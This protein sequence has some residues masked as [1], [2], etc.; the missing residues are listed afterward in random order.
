MSQYLL[1]IDQGTSSSRAVIYDHSVAV[2][3]SAQQE[4]PQIYAQAGWVE[5]DPE[6]IWSSVRVVIRRAMQKVGAAASDVTAIGVTN[7]RETTLIWDRETG[8]SVYNAIVWQDRRTAE[9]CRELKE[10]GAEAQIAHGRPASALIP[11][12]QRPRLRGFSTTSRAFGERAE[13]GKLAFGT[14]DCFL[15]WRL[16]G[17]L[18]ACDGCKQRIAD[19]ALQYSYTRMGR[20]A[21]QAFRHTGSTVARGQRL[22]CGFRHG[23]RRSVWLAQYR[24]HGHGR[25]P[26]GRSVWAGR[27]CDV[28]MT[29]STYGTG[30]F[31]IANTGAEALELKQSI[32]D[33]GRH[34]PQSVK[35]TYGLEGSVFV[36]GSAMQ[37]LR[38]GLRY[39]SDGGRIRSYCGAH[40]NCR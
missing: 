34:A 1:A 8:E 38:D 36:A 6:V 7:Q 10:D 35:G 2:V 32:A 5:H 25:R 27:V 14:V 23:D 19:H 26:A 40:R 33:D 39:H 28:G 9:R 20:R 24:C 3:G 31:A 15:L 11:I 29:K 30:C 18:A 22:R 21:A 13:A 12:F 37:W 16:S 4:F 17:R